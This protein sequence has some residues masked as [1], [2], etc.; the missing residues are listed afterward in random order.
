MGGG[1]IGLVYIQR[2]E[3]K[4]CP[5]Q[6][7]GV[8]IDLEVRTNLEVGPDLSMGMIAKFK[9]GRKIQGFK[10]SWRDPMTKMLR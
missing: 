6:G 10:Y 8:R 3:I 7:V 5:Y 2:I 4:L 9:Q 1:G